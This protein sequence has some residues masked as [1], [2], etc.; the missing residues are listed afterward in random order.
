MKEQCIQEDA[1]DLWTIFEA[2][3]VTPAVQGTKPSL[4]Q[5][6]ES[7]GISVRAVQRRLTRSKQKFRAILRQTV[8]DY[9]PL[10]GKHGD[11]LL[12]SELMDLIQTAASLKLLTV[13]LDDSG[14][15]SLFEFADKTYE[16]EYSKQDCGELWSSIAAERL[17]SFAL[18]L[19][20]HSI[21][22]AILEQSGL[23]TVQQ[24]WSFPSP[25]MSL[26]QL[27]K[28]FAKKTGKQSMHD[29]DSAYPLPICIALY[30][31]AIATAWQRYDQTRLSRMEPSAL[32]KRLPTVLAYDWLDADARQLLESWREDLK[33]L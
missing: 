26:L 32:L 13:S 14:T 24:L 16:E 18:E 25:P 15:L 19:G 11:G 17:E 12:E 8:A 27:I 6:A 9:L 31:L 22:F 5:L 30:Q 33:S 2:R 10:V 21:D 23:V 3:I 7:V 20:D 28:E 4:G 1:L 29:F